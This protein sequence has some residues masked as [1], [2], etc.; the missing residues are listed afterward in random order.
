MISKKTAFIFNKEDEKKG[1]ENILIN[2]KTVAIMY[3]AGILEMDLSEGFIIQD[4]LIGG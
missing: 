3:E 2:E 1:N 4:P